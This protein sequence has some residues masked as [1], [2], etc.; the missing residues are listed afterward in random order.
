MFDHFYCFLED[1][2]EHSEFSLHELTLIGGIRLK[3]NGPSMMDDKFIP[4]LSSN[5][6]LWNYALQTTNMLNW[7]LNSK[8][9]YNSLKIK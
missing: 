2:N 5:I 4:S 9:N 6:D 8:V 7:E 1:L 3:I